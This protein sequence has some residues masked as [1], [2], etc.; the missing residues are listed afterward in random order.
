MDSDSDFESTSS[1]NP[2]ALECFIQETVKVPFRDDQMEWIACYLGQGPHQDIIFQGIFQHL[3]SYL[4]S[5]V[6]PFFSPLS[7][8]TPW[9]TDSSLSVVVTHLVTKRG[10]LLSS[11]VI[12]IL[13]KYA[14]TVL[15]PQG[16]PSKSEGKP[17]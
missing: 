9:R 2:K 8:E 13:E 10:P 6:N 12:D 11:V 14:Q 16:P 7:S 1:Y 5:N 4:K 3:R 15:S 17:I